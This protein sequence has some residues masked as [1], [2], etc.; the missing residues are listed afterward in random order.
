MVCTPGMV[1]ACA[2]PELLVGESATVTV[3]IK[4]GDVRLSSPMPV[5]A[6]LQVE[7]LTD[8]YDPNTPNNVWRAAWGESHI[9]LPL[10]LHGF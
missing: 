6:S 4:A 5:R 3:Q 7:I 2:A 9:Y 10:I 1:V 8:I